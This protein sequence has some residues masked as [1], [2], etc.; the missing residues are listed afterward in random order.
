MKIDQLD[1]KIL[2]LLQNSEMLAPKL[3]KIAEAVG[4]TNATVYRRIEALKREGIIVGH[5]TQ[6]DAK[7]IGKSVQ[8]FIHLRVSNNLEKGER[9]RIGKKLSGLEGVEAVYVPISHWNYLLKVRYS[10]IEEL[11]RFIQDELVKMPV[12]EM[13]IEL[14]SKSIKDGAVSLFSK[15]E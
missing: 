7:L 13:Q 12:E 8:S 9:D 1:I 3:T 5:T 2:N 15:K 14:V 6:V 4:S 11:D 10:N